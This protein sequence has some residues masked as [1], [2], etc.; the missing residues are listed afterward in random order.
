MGSNPTPSAIKYSYHIDIIRFYGLIPINWYKVW[1]KFMKK[2]S[3]G[4]Q[5]F[6][7]KNGTYYY[8]RVIPARYRELAGCTEFKD[9]LG[10]KDYNVALEAYIRISLY[11]EDKMNS[12]KKGIDIKSTHA[13]VLD[14]QKYAEANGL[15]SLPIEEIINS[16]HELKKRISIFEK[17]KSSRQV[18]FESLFG[19]QR[20]GILLSQ[21][22]DFYE[23]SEKH[24]LSGLTERKLQKLLNPKKLAVKKL[25]EFLGEDISLSSLTRSHAK[26]FHT[27]LKNSIADKVI[28]GNTAG[29]YIT[30]LRVLIKKYYSE[31]DIEEDT[32]FDGLNFSY[33]ENARPPFSVEFLKASW[34]NN[35]VFNLMH[36]DARTLLF[37]M[38]DTGSHAS[39]LIGL[40]PEKEIVLDAK[41]PHIIIQ[42]NERRNLKTSHRGRVIPLIGHAL[43]AFKEHP[44][45]FYRYSGSNGEDKASAEINKFLKVNNLKETD[46]HVLYGLRHT[47]KD[48]LR[49]HGFDPELQ[50]YLMGHLDKSM[51]AHYGLGYGLE[52][53]FEYM[54]KLE[55]D[56]I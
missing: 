32:V 54:K 22:V 9:S 43:K 4:P 11:Y 38:L 16:P 31:M 49:N 36:P 26:A 27:E 19:L 21:L 34:I 23:K 37:V 56:F 33:R 39:E 35:P 51:G 7:I 42:H 17:A 18:E 20:Q 10:T 30:H 8:R 12:L 14:Y 29:K 47:F 48:R 53:S 3:T 1:Y 45:G 44:V 41:I 24:I 50:N 46:K 6:C 40:I 52:K 5:Y 2:V 25:I 28:L 15:T 13:S 55:G